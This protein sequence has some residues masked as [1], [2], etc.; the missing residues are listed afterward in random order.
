VK[1]KDDFIYNQPEK[2]IRMKIINQQ[3]LEDIIEQAKSNVRLRM[4]FNIHKNLTDNVQQLLN[5]LEPGTIVPVHRHR[6][7]SETYI[8][9]KGSLKVYFYDDQKNI[10]ET[11][12]LSHTS[13]NYGINI[14]A[15]QW[16]T[17]EVLET[18]TV[19]YE[20]KEGPYMPLEGE[21]II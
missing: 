16:H 10:A 21:D 1:S 15:G 5:A 7:T 6:N 12:Q 2:L 9:L 13:G 14:P 11:L 3:L 19:I 8:L 17:I 4:N 18:G 20:I